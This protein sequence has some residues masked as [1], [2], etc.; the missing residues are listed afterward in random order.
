MRQQK[1]WRYYC[2]F[3][4]KV[5]GQRHAM[6]KHEKACTANP[7]RVCGLCQHCGEDQPKLTTLT[8]F[9]DSYCADLPRVKFEWDD[10]EH[11]EASGDKL[12]PMLKELEALANHCPACTLA[13]LRQAKTKTWSNFNFKAKLDA[14]WE[15]ENANR[16]P[17][18]Y[19]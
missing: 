8:G 1:R 18:H 13:A 12:D 14:W 16:E 4:K 19:Y 7:E 10:E 6:E 5:G 15:E 17:E 9:I 3:C 11:L 2:D